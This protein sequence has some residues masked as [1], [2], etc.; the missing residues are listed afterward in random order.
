MNWMFESRSKNWYDEDSEVGTYSPLMSFRDIL[1]FPLFIILFFVFFGIFELLI[2]V[3]IILHEF[4]SV[5]KRVSD[6]GKLESPGLT[7]MGAS[8]AILLLNLI[9]NHIFDVSD[10]PIIT[11]CA[12]T[13][14]IVFTLAPLTG[15]VWRLCKQKPAFLRRR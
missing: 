4:Y 6:R 15:L 14:I 7:L 8:L 12:A 2:P 1:L 10:H 5:A 9:S 13:F 3:G 11:F